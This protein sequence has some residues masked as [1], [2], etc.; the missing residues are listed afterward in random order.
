M[1]V[2]S[3]SEV[4]Q[5]CPTLRDPMDCSLPGP[6]IHGIFQESTGVGRHCRMT[7][8]YLKNTKVGKG[9][10]VTFCVRKNLQSNLTLNAHI[11]GIFS[12][13]SSINQINLLLICIDEDPTFCLGVCLEQNMVYQ[14]DLTLCLFL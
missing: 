11:Q 9:S 2:K 8:I 4:A 7:N 14:P 13:D 10:K 5:S 6:A 12:L 3:E 1:K